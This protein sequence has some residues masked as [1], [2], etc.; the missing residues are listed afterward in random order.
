MLLLSEIEP[1]RAQSDADEFRRLATVYDW[2]NQATTH[3]A[4]VAVGLMCMELVRM[5]WFLTV[6]EALEA[7]HEKRQA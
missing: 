6:L 3:A 5:P 1:G 4:N 7:F 2:D